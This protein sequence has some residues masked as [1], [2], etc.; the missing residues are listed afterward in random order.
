M[1]D[2]E[3]IENRGN[4]RME[5]SHGPKRSGASKREGFVLQPLWGC[6]TTIVKKIKGK[7]ARR[8][9]KRGISSAC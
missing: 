7:K 8:V 4:N 2:I 1:G 6:K 5:N 9:Y 3:N